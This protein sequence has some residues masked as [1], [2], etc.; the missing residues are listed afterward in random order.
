MRETLAAFR[1][2]IFD[3]E[4]Y[5]ADDL[6][7]ALSLQAQAQGVES[8]IVSG[9]LDM[10]QLVS[11]HT[12]LMF[13]RMG[14]SAT[15]MYDPARIHERYGLTP[16][17]MIDFKALKGDTTDNIP[18]LA[19]VGD[20]TAAKL[21]EDYGSLDG[22]FERIDEV[23]PDKLRDKLAAAR[24][25]LMLWRELVTIDREAPVHAGPRGGAA[26]R[27]RPCRGHPAVPG[28]RVPDA[29][30]AAAGGGRRG[31]AGA[32]RP[33]PRGRSGWAGAGSPGR[34]PE[35]A[36]RRPW[37]QRA[38]AEP[39]LRERVRRPGAMPPSR[40][41]GGRSRLRSRTHG[42]DPADLL[43]EVL[44]DPAAVGAFAP[45]RRPRRVARERNRSS[46]VG[47][48]FDDPRPRRGT[49]LGFAI[50]GADGRR[51][52]RRAPTV[53]RR[54]PSGVIGTGLPLAGPRRQAAAR[55]GAGAPRPDARPRA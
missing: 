14:A 8:V 22:V 18:G 5:E 11:E 34:G 29:R 38:P 17:Q 21:L 50:T 27:L 51:R 39:R 3:L 45:G 46:T 9:D 26:G 10:L 52:G 33:A 40:S 44:R 43:R 42:G 20:K 37:R 16:H 15:I 7:G 48:A 19:G 2:P 47:A 49:L 13:T 4:G 23:K 54:S 25:D 32:R 30:G 41:Q 36:W 6:I 24:D 31:A 55:V 53:P 1:I 35:R 12:R 28:V